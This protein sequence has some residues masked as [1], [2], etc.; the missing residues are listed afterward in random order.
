MKDS[1]L[2][3]MGGLVGF[4]RRVCVVLVPG[5]RARLGFELRFRI[6]GLPLSFFG[7]S[8]KIFSG[9]PF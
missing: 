1:M 3:K 7:V 6:Q 2:K 9:L 5:V 4:R 8:S